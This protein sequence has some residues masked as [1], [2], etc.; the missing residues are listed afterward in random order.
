MASYSLLITQSPFSDSGHELALDFAQAL[1][2]EGHSLE[3]V[4][5][6]QDAVYAALNNQTPTQGQSSLALRWLALKQEHEISLQVCIANA[7]RRGVLNHQE[8]QRY[9][10]SSVTL[11]EGFELVGLGEMA[12]ACKESNRV[13]TF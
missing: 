3:R 8:Q 7:I 2:V 9:Q 1:L 6:Y 11:M 13:I 10:A 5:F 12:S 4:F